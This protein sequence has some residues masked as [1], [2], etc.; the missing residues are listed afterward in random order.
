MV[1]I[2][3][4]CNGLGCKYLPDCTIYVTLEPCPMCAAA[5][6]WAKIGRVVY[7]ADD[8]KSGFM[9]FGKAMLHPKTSV[10]FGIMKQECGHLMSK[11]FLEKRM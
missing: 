10:A 2:T 11:F 5:L 9:K 1:A 3:A 6:S 7:A 4:A 8:D